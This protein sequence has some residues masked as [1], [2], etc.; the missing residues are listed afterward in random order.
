MN[1]T[2]REKKIAGDNDEKRL[3]V[4]EF[5]SKKAQRR[6]KEAAEKGFFVREQRLKERDVCC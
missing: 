1:E 6:L 5:R 4:T 3:P 2:K